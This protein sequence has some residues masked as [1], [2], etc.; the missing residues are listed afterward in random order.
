MRHF[1]PAAVIIP[2][3][4]AC[5]SPARPETTRRCPRGD[6]ARERV[7]IAYPST[8]RS[9]RRVRK[10]IALLG[11]KLAEAWERSGWN[12]D[13]ICKPG[14]LVIIHAPFCRPDP[15]NEWDELVGRER[16]VISDD[17]GVVKFEQVFS[18]LAGSPANM[19][20]ASKGLFLPVE[21]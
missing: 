11:F 6:H 19:A 13:G 1:D 9:A 4:S 5:I 21:R 16:S 2:L 17:Q 10:K 20:C 18:M 7:Q 8:F 15:I 3:R 12:L 14:L